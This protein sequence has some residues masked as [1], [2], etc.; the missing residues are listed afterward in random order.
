MNP[1][2]IALA[3]LGAFVAYFVAGG[4][5]V[6]DDA[7]AEDGVHEVSGGVPVAR[8]NE[9]GDAGGDGGDG[10]LVRGVR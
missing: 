1:M 8:R 4:S 7:V 2:R 5:H 10:N 9:A 6:C 3:A